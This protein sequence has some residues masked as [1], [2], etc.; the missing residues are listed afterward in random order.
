MQLIAGIAVFCVAVAIRLAMIWRNRRR[1]CDAYYFLFSADELRRNHR[2][3]IT[4]PLVYVLEKQEQWYPPGFSVFLSMLPKALVTKY[5]WFI[6][7]A[8]DSLIALLVYSVSYFILGDIWLAV[9]AGIAYSMNVASIVDTTSLNARSLGALL[10]NLCWLLVVYALAGGSLV[11]VV[12]VL[13]FLLLMTH[14]LSSQLLYF[15]A[16]FISIVLGD[17]RIAVFVSGIVLFAYIASGGFLSKIWRGQWDI[18]NYWRKQWR[19]LGAHQI[20][21]SPMYEFLPKLGNRRV[22]L[23]GWKGFVKSASYM[24][25]NPFALMLI[26]PILHYR[27]LSVFDSWML[28]WAVGTYLLAVLTQ[29]VSWL[30]FAGEGYRYLKLAALPVCYLAFVPVLYGWAEWHYY[31]LLTVCLIAAIVL[32]IRLYH[33]MS[34]ETT[35]PFMD[36]GLGD[37]IKYL[38]S[39]PTNNILCLTEGLAEA[40]GYYTRKSVLRGSHNVYLNEILPFFPVYR[41][42]LEYLTKWYAVS[43]VVISKKYVKAEYLGLDKKSLVLSVDD[44]EVYKVGG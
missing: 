8:L 11:Y 16:V 3:P 28:W 25:M 43:H 5:Y 17:W 30:R 18:M 6:S 26:Y 10:F 34:H 2:L 19:N 27:E 31:V 1:G 21:D 7:P 35:I 32:L 15:L 24:G 13:G 29:F 20:Y 4:L 9:F 14:K 38:K 33:F 23:Q 44:C 12:L 22:H 40:I 41:L 37:V 42:P 36:T 39:V